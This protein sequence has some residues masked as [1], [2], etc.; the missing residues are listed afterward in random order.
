MC[1]TYYL[2]LHHFDPSCFR[3]NNQFDSPVGYG[4]AKQYYMQ[5]NKSGP[6]EL[7]IDW[8]ESQSAGSGTDYCYGILII[9][10]E[11]FKCLLDKVYKKSREWLSSIDVN[12]NPRSGF[13]EGAEVKIDIFND[14]LTVHQQKIINSETEIENSDE[15]INDLKA[16]LY[17]FYKNKFRRLSFLTD[18]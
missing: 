8:Q 1:R 16:G 2:I 14:L 13:T 9:D 6:P 3:N 11:S 18:H 5:I 4:A 15:S 12:G 7:V 17:Y 10:L